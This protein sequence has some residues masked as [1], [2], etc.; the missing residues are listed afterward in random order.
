MGE[1]ADGL[2]NGDFD[3]YTGEYIGRGKGYPRTLDK[4]LPWEK[5]DY[6]G[7]KDAAFKG[8]KRYLKRFL[9]ITDITP[10]VDLYMPGT[11]LS[12]KQKCLAI[13][14]DFGAFV[15]WVSEYKRTTG[16]KN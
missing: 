16:G 4:S 5:P 10:V 11:E 9:S 6:T 1:I 2:I 14:K 7:S 13:Q 3:A 15:K 12:L 8:L